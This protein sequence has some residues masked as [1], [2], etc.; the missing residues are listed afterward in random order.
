MKYCSAC[1]RVTPGD[2]LFCNSCGS[3]YDV[4][5]CPRLHRNSRHAEVCSECGSR[6][7]STPQPRMPFLKRILRF[8]ERTLI[9]SALMLLFLAFV[10]GL[11]S[12]KEGQNA[13]VG[14]GVVAGIVW[15]LWSLIPEG[16]KKRIHRT[17]K[18]PMKGHKE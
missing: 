4:K 7:F 15:W 11:L 3:S 14:F 6:E 8:G 17:R 12:T 1:G 5:L 13:F 10:I 9:A 18:R 16:I 2:P